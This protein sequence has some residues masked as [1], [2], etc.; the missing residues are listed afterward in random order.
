VQEAEAYKAQVLAKAQGETSRFLQVMA[1]YEKAPVI[2]KER[3]YL[4]TMESV[5]SNSQK[6]LVDV[7]NDSNTMLYLPLDRL[8]GS[9][10]TTA[11]NRI[12]LSNMTAYPSTNTTI[13]SAPA[14]TDSRSRGG[15]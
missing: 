14:V 9:Q 12:D 11:S 1:E 6:V 13:N 15:R 7:D 2:T 10:R 8:G 5:Y 4:D 3:L